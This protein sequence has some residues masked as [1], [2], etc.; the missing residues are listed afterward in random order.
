MHAIRPAAESDLAAV[1]Q[2]WRDAEAPPSPTDDTEALQ[3][4]LV[5]DPGALLVAAEGEALIGSVIAGWDGWRGGI[6]R[7]AVHPA[8][9][10]RGLGRALVAEATARIAARGARRITALVMRDDPQAVS[11]WDASDAYAPDPLHVRYVAMPA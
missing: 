10:R 3:Q 5:A 4:L 8:H 1:L 9:R 7:L 2:L 11:F 6:Y